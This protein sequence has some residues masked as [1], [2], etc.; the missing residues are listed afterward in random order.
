MKYRI[1]IITYQNA[2]SIYIPQVKIKILWMPLNFEGAIDIIPNPCLS[3]NDALKCIDL[4][5]DG[6]KKIKHI[7]FEYIYRKLDTQDK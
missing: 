4:N 7:Y 6:N 5:L 1:K 3:R 2:R